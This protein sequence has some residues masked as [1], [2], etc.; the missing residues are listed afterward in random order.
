MIRQLGLFLWKPCSAASS[1][2]QVVE[3][4]WEEVV[5]WQVL[6]GEDRWDFL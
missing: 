1:C 3:L 6:R 5:L 4:V 2:S